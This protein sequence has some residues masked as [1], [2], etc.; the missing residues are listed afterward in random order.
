MQQ[1]ALVRSH[2]SD[3]LINK[4]GIIIGKALDKTEGGIDNLNVSELKA[5][6]VKALMITAATAQDKQ[7]LLMG[8]PSRITETQSNLTS[9]ADQFAAIVAKRAEKVVSD[10]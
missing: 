6:D 8:L 3:E 2:K 4:L 10:Q 1:V 7:R 9:M 5:G